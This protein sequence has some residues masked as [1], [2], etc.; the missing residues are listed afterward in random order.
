MARDLAGRGVDV[1]VCSPGTQDGPLVDAGVAHVAIGGVLAVPANGSRAPITLSPSAAR[2]FASVA[3]TL[4]GGVVH[5][6]EPFAPIAAYGILR[7]HRR[8][9]VATFHRGGGGPAYVAGR[10]VIRRL[11]S[12][13][14]VATAVSEHAAETIAGAANISTEVLFNGF[15]IDRIR[16][17][18]PWPTDAPT[19]VF[20]GRHEPRK[21]LATLLEAFS[22]I[23]LPIEC[24]VLG[25]GPQT[26]A[27]RRQYDAD[28]RI[29]WLGA[30][31]DDDK[32]SRMKGADV[33]CVPSMGGESFGLVPL[34]GMAAGTAVVA[35]DIP[36]YREATAGNA[37]LVAPGD[38]DALAVAL[39]HAIEHPAAKKALDAARAHAAHWSIHSLVTSYL[40]LYEKAAAHFDSLVR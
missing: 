34:E 14:D 21:G 36:G 30:L 9:V 16:A 6:H 12:G 1:V 23:P 17:A 7:A 4:R 10:S 5:V 20:V 31:G 24:W 27:L 28:R 2:T 22:A 40:E 29:S 8:P 11:A 3:A 19:V 35:S 39:R 15:E 18:T 13:I 25:D 32:F 37:T 26:A 38:A 33:L